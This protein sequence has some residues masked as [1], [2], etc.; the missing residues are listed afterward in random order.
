MLKVLGAFAP[1]KVDH[2]TNGN[3]LL[4]SSI[5]VPDNSRN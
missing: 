2:T 1:V 4:S 3:D 5:M